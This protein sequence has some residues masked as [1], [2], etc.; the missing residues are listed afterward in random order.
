M[1]KYLFDIFEN[2]EH[3]DHEQHFLYPPK[4][5]I[6]ILYVPN[7]LSAELTES[8]LSLIQSKESQIL[9]S[10]QPNQVAGLN[11]GLTTRWLDYNIFSWQEDSA[12]EYKKIVK[13]YF[14]LYLELSGAE[15][16]EAKAQSWANNLLPG[17]QLFEHEHNFRFRK[18]SN[19]TV[20]LNSC[21]TYTQFNFPF[22]LK[23]QLKNAIMDHI[24]FPTR[25]GHLILIPGW[26]KHFTSINHSESKRWTLGFDISDTFTK[27]MSCSF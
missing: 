1:S 24:K 23:S 22:H 12:Q 17:E 27:G 25:K 2:V 6:P 10:S 20:A 16:F 19:G 4:L 5:K 7:A 15:S 18:C 3:G 8:L 11:D 14:D 26:L 21:E 13:E 9:S